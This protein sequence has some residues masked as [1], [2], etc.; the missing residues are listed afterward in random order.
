MGQNGKLLDSKGRPVKF[1]IETNAGN[2]VREGVGNILTA[3]LK[4]LGMDITFV[5]G[6]FNTM[7]N[8]MLNVGDWDAI[9]LGLT[10]SD[11]P[12]GGNNVW[13]INGSLH[14]WNLS[15]EVADWVD[16]KTYVV[17]E[18]E[19]QIDKIFKENVRILDD[20]VVK[21]YWAQ[22]PEDYI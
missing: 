2:N 10:G 17:P 6:D 7:I 11:E 13:S 8:R 20:N 3:A 21:D 14:F 22:M 5:P 18:F 15:P 12:Q 4:Q 16:P 1:I 19:K 9:I